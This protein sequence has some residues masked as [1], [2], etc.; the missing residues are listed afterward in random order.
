MNRCAALLV[1]G[2]R[3]PAEGAEGTEAPFAPGDSG[4]RTG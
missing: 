3:G 4:S 1:F 2:F